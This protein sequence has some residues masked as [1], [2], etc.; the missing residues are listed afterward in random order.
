MTSDERTQLIDDLVEGQLSEADFLRLEAELSIDPVA[1]KEYYGRLALTALLE[2][3]AASPGRKVISFPSRQA[4]A[5]RWWAVA[6]GFVAL[7][8]LSLFLF[9]QPGAESPIA[10][11][12]KEQR[13]SGFAVVAGQANAVWANEPPLADGSLLPAGPLELQS[14]LAQLELFSGVTVVA[15]GPAAFEVI[16]PMELAVTRGKIRAH[17]P[18]PAQGFRIRTEAGEVVDLG[19]EFAVDIT[20]THADL[21][22]LDGEVEWH[23]RAQAMRSLQKGEALRWGSD[24]Q[25]LALTADATGFIGV[26]ELRDQLA[27]ARRDRQDAWWQFSQRLQ[28]DERL[29]AYY[30]M[31]SAT[32]WSRQLDN[33]A[34][35][36]G[37]TVGEGAIVAARRTGDRWGNPDGAL[38]FSPTGSRVRLNVPGEYHSLTLL[39]WVKINSLDRWYNSLFLTD[40]HELHE[41]HWQIMDDGRLFFSVKKN[42]TWDPKKG[43]KDKHIFYSP[44]FWEPSLSG[45]WLMIATTYDIAAK[46]VTHYL[47]GKV[48]SRES[49]PDEYLVPAVRIGNASL[50]NWGLP[51]R[52]DPRFAVR[53]LNGSM[54][55]FALFKAALSDAEIQ[56]IYDHGR[57]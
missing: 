19:T 57:L 29:V 34:S 30:Q 12:P 53:N 3:E 56:N 25:G 8:G 32:G 48:L 10:E 49:I 24:G 55:E 51:E 37:T 6:A 35:A 21:H 54:S 5:G 9:R 26:N 27:L 38:D 42:D 47:N 15:E 7:L 13:A 11:S 46:Q 52:D 39:C 14:G 44:S 22:V 45:Q 28:D 16:S 4:T 50:G 1:R 33:L 18:E 43:E 41:P 17:V 40:G 2:N 31:K 20:P 23:P 36:G